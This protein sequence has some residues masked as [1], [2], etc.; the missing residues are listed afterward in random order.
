MSINMVTLPKKSV[1]QRHVAVGLRSSR[2]SD[3]T[4]KIKQRRL[5]SSPVACA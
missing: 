5:W 4:N 3:W 2:F 1:L